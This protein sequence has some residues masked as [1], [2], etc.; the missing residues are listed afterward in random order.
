MNMWVGDSLMPFEQK[1]M[2][3]SLTEIVNSER[4]KHQMHSKVY[5]D[6]GGGFCEEHTLHVEGKTYRQPFPCGI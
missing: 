1:R 6:L 4:E 3:V 5:Y 2:P